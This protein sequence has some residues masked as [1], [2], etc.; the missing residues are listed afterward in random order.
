MSE[1][2]NANNWL[3]VSFRSVCNDVRY[4]TWFYLHSN[5]LLLSLFIIFSVSS[6]LFWYIIHVYYIIILNA[7]YSH[8]CIFFLGDDFTWVFILRECFLYFVFIY[9]SVYYIHVYITSTNEL[10]FYLNVHCI[11]FSPLEAN[12]SNEKITKSVDHANSGFLKNNQ[13]SKK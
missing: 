10:V 9:I 4:W 1:S 2:R 7:L 6:Q 12:K 5:M 13:H 8:S 11:L 3:L